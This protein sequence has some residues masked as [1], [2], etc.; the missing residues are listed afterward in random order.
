VSAKCVGT[1]GVGEIEVEVADRG[2]GIPAA[3]IGRIFEP[4]F[5]GSRAVRDQIH[6]TGLGLNIVRSIAE[7]HGGS[8]SVTSEAEA[9]THFFLR[10]PCAENHN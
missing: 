7:A 5:R 8:V 1:R 9:G 2:P 10:I 4:F 6:G 3:E